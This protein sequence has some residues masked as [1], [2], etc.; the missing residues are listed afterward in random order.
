V[1]VGEGRDD[2]KKGESYAIYD[3]DD[4]SSDNGLTVVKGP[5]KPNKSNRRNQ[6]S[7]QSSFSAGNRSIAMLP[8]TMLK[9]GENA[10]ELIEPVTKIGDELFPSP[11]P[12][13]L[14]PSQSSSMILL[15]SDDEDAD[16]S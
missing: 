10:P 1:D 9:F 16:M 3:E 15:D 5:S 13:S 7:S 6:S 12:E 8:S 4:S 11:S 2:E 14:R